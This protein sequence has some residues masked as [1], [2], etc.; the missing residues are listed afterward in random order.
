MAPTG[1]EP[2]T[3]K[4]TAGRGLRAAGVVALV[5]FVLASV[6][7]L[8][9]YVRQ[10]VDQSRAREAALV[11]RIDKLQQN[12]GLIASQLGSREPT[13]SAKATP[14]PG[15][16]NG[17]AGSYIPNPLSSAE[18]KM[19][20]QLVVGRITGIGAEKAFGW[21]AKVVVGNF[22]DGAVGFSV[23][24]SHGDPFNGSYY[25]EESTKTLDAQLLRNAPMTV[26]GWPGTGAR[27]A[28]QVSAAQL[29]SILSQPGPGGAWRGT[30]FW[31]KMGP[32]Q[33][34]LGGQQ[35]TPP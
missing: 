3:A 15:P 20:V 29:A 14:S 28:T 25:V 4:P 5:V 13:A 2:T 27:A 21:P 8:G 12:Q 35:L 33:E 11:D 24:S 30:W 32:N 16:A 7:M 26:Y 31:L 19:G 6:A 1:V 9:L 18:R 23:A 10:I 17:A 34:V 22:L